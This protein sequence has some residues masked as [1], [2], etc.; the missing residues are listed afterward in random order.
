MASRNFNKYQ[1]LEKEVK[2]LFAEVAI[3]A[4][5]G[6]VAVDHDV[7]AEGA[8]S[9]R[10]DER[11]LVGDDEIEVRRRVDRRTGRAH[12]RQECSRQH[13]EWAGADVLRERRCRL[14]RGVG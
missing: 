11:R 7:D 1:A 5:G 8:A 3:G 10:H 4:A 2:T 14:S 13:D 9:R 6:D 12:Q